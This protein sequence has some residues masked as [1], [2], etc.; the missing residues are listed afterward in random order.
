LYF[1][2]G[3]VT[4]TTTLVLTPT[5]AQGGAGLAFAGHAF[6]IGTFRDGHLLSCHLSLF[7]LFGPTHQMVLPLILRHH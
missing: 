5:L 1:P 4:E 7:G 6:E 2:A 3:V